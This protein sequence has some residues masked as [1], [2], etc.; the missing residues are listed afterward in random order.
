[1]MRFVM[2]C[3]LK[4]TTAVAL[5]GCATM[6]STSAE[7]AA[8]KPAAGEDR[9]DALSHY[10]TSEIYRYRGD[11]RKW[12]H[13]LEEAAAMDP[14]SV[15]LQL[16]LI[17]AYSL[18]K[19]YD[20]AIQVAESTLATY[21]DD[22][23]LYIWLGRLQYETGE[24]DESIATFER[25]LEVDPSSTRALEALA[26]LREQTN[27]LV[28]EV[29]MYE[30]LV[31][32]AP[33]SPQLRY[34]YGNSLFQLG[35]EEAARDA[36]LKAIEIDP[37]FDPARYLLG[38]VY[39]DLNE[40]DLAIEQFR[41]FL[42]R[43]PDHAAARTNLAVTLARKGEYE[44][45]QRE[46]ANVIE[47][48]DVEPRHHLYR[49]YL[50]LR[51]G[52]KPD[53]SDAIAPSSAPIFGSLLMAMVRKEAGEPYER[54][55]SGLDVIEGDLDAESSSYLNNLLAMFGPDDA[56][57]FLEER[58]SELVEDGYRTKAL[59]T[60]RAR[61]LMSR[62]LVAEAKPMLEGILERYGE[63]KWT[64]YYLAN[65][66]EQLDQPADV[67]YHLRQCLEIDPDDPDVLNFLGYYLADEN[68]KLE[69][70]EE[71]VERALELDPENGYYLDSLGWV[72]Y[73]QGKGE[74]AVEY[75]ER[76][77]RNMPS[78]DAILRDHLG[79]AYLMVGDS[80]RAVREWRRAHRLDPELEG[81]IE[82]INR[83]TE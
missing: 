18:F 28:A 22:V 63:D 75:I 4:M 57:A 79:D 13:S 41:E 20:Q 6:T 43:A 80:K 1:M 16:R 3:L 72:Y 7:R 76:A 46:L 34:Q 67:E 50:M 17:G 9:A 77:I 64:H 51:Q 42:V 49:M 10:L 12:L 59:E 30:K 40:L 55:L 31:H 68:M 52:G 82:K 37:K 47:S 62:E 44:T 2:N 33:D 81:V 74:E 29:E 66:N 45:A 58:F 11:Y 78:D 19:N 83:Y 25:A 24:I 56:G 39:L 23:T 5:V 60:F 15:E 65:A 36:L 21:P 73:R 14:A 26:E 61:A 70:A 8:D 48:A 71:L 54:L 69:E 32:V 27:D 53:A 38:V 35:E